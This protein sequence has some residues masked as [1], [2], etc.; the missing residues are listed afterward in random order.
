MPPLQ[1]VLGETRLV[2]YRRLLPWGA[3]AITGLFLIAMVWS[4]IAGRDDR[5]EAMA[6]VAGFMALIALL[7]WDV[8][9]ILSRV[10]RAMNATQPKP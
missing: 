2:F 6:V 7:G 9:R 8:V 1:R 10:E 5:A 3:T 4:M